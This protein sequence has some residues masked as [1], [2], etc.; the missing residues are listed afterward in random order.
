MILASLEPRQRPQPATWQRELADAIA[1]PE[2][3]LEA[4]GL[5]PRLAG[6][7]RLAARSFRLRVPWSYVRRMRRGDAGDPL[8]RQVLPLQEE[9]AEQPGFSADPLGERAALATPALLQKYRGRALLIAT[10]ACAVHCRYC[11]RREF[12][13]AEQDGPRWQEA[14]AHIERDDGIEE[15]ILSGGDPLSLSDARLAALTRSLEGAAHVRRLRI[16]TR[17][18]IV[19]PARVDD[20]LVAWLASLRWPTV[21]VLHA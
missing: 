4:L 9:L 20:G 7:A 19:L 18:P 2:A 3:L 21:V 8:L 12:P 6:P 1:T 15:V 10:A 17:L 5:D 11:F 14:L 16:H 13:Y